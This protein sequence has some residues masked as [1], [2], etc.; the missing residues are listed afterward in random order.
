MYFWRYW[1]MRYINNYPYNIFGRTPWK[2]LRSLPLTHSSSQISWEDA[3]TISFRK[4]HLAAVRTWK[5]PPTHTFAYNWVINILLIFCYPCP[6]N[7]LY[8]CIYLH[9]PISQDSLCILR[10][11]EIMDFYYLGTIYSFVKWSYLPH[12]GTTIHRYTYF[13]YQLN[14][15]VKKDAKIRIYRHVKKN[16]TN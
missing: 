1:M 6:H 14:M 11:N 3:L 12:R 15:H 9:E 4:V 5:L 16:R 13:S 8:I 10:T 2:Q 7:L